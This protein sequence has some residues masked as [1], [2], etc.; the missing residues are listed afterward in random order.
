[1]DMSALPTKRNLI[2]AKTNLT[3]SEKGCGLLDTKYKAL[4]REAARIKKEMQ[5]KRLEADMLK[6]H[7]DKLLNFAQMEINMEKL[8][9]T[10]TGGLTPLCYSLEGTTVL[11]DEAVLAHQIAESKLEELREIEVIFLN[12]QNN[13]QRTRKRLMALKNI[14]IPLYKLY[15]K[16][17]SERLEETIRDELVRIKVSKLRINQ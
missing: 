2:I 3:E 10:L 4:L 6:K 11:L 9:I 16:V 8:N 7:A 12:L 5:E 13:M 15:I 1:M 17:I 14:K